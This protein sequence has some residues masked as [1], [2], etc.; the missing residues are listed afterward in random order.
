MIGKPRL[1]HCGHRVFCEHVVVI[2]SGDIVISSGSSGGG[3][4]YKANRPNSQSDNREIRMHEGSLTEF[5]DTNA[6]RVFGI[7]S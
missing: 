4:T 3:L 7:N 5:A 6:K 2:E 1:T